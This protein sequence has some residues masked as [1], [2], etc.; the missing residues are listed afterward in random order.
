MKKLVLLVSVVVL[1][2]SA[3]FS[4]LSVSAN[5]G[6]SVFTPQG[7]LTASSISN[8][9]MIKADYKFNDKYFAGLGFG[10]FSQ[11]LDSGLQ[12]SYLSIPLSVGVVMPGETITPV[13]ALGYNLRLSNKFVGGTADNFLVHSLHWR[14]G[15]ELNTGKQTF[16]TIGVSGNY[17]LST[18]STLTGVKGSSIN[19][20]VGFGVRLGKK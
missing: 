18:N 14:V 19:L 3:G 12:V 10:T 7:K 9:A 17:D 13:V 8:F 16:T 11:A 5:P 20:F 4:Q 6:L 2:I 1:G 15:L